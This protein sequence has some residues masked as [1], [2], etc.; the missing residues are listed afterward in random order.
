MGSSGV[1]GASGWDQQL[2]GLSCRTRPTIRLGLAAPLGCLP[3]FPAP[4]SPCLR[5]PLRRHWRPLPGAGV[6][7]TLCPCGQSAGLAWAPCHLL[8]PRQPW[9]CLVTPPGVTHRPE[10]P[11]DPKPTGS[12]PWRPSLRVC[13]WGGGGWGATPHRDRTLVSHIAGGFFTS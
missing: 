2:G 8:P 7:G 4:S 11:A 10:L 9:A 5:A 1:H 12:P 6:A 3:H 13:F